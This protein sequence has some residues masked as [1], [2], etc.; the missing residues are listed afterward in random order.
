MHL[1]VVIPVYNEERNI[2]ALLRDWQPVFEAT[3]T[4]YRVIL[5]DDGSTDRS[6]EVLKALREKDHT[7]SVHTQPNAGHGAAI[8]RGY[9]LAVDAGANT[10]ANANWVFQIDSD[11][12]LETTAFRKLWD[13][14]EHYDL[15]LA[16]RKVKNAS[17]ARRC[18]SRVSRAIVR[19]LFGR[20]ITEGA[21]TNEGVTNG[22]K[23]NR[24]ITDVNTPYRLIRSGHLREALA[25]I[26]DNSFAPNILLTAWFIG[27]KR[28]IFTT[29]TELRSGPQQRK[30]QMNG[31][32]LRGALLSAYQTLLFRIR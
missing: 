26:P 6:P 22:A 19:G 24:T 29:T 16:E 20:G 23:T 11:H 18:L 17:F 4:P 25:K 5:I 8:L 2:T 28:R 30:S 9:R 14:R 31:Y 21:L 3:G 27:K 12:Q 15:L 13:N 7:L 10:E 1:A 32:F